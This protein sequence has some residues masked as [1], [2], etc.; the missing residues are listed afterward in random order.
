MFKSELTIVKEKA[1]CLLFLHHLQP[2]NYSFFIAVSDF[3]TPT[4]K[5]L[6][7]VKFSFEFLQARLSTKL[8]PWW[9][10]HVAQSTH[11]TLLLFRILFI[12]KAPSLR[13]F[14]QRTNLDAHLRIHS[15]Y[16]PHACDFCGKSFSQKGN[17]EE[18]RRVSLI[19]SW[20]HEKSYS[21]PFMK[22]NSPI[23]D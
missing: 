2:E 21:E 16:K 8:L 12:R 10:A 1:T 23:Y 22:H 15:G 6:W 18:H 5:A 9:N 17:M 13:R 20:F 4:A 3:S 11:C 19:T 14:T 7:T